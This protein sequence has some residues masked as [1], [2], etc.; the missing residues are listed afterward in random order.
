MNIWQK[1]FGSKKAPPVPGASTPEGLHVDLLLSAEPKNETTS[2]THMSDELITTENVSPN[3]LKTIFDAAFMESSIDGDGDLVV[4]DRCN[5][6]LLVSENK[7]RIT[8]YVRFGFKSSASR[9]ERLECANKINTEW[10]IVRARVSDLNDL[11]VFQYDILIGPGLSK[12]AL[13][14]AVKRFCGIPHTAV[15]EHGGGLIE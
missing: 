6:V 5:C 14:L 3:F 4:K 1:C 2:Q 9:L 13:V 7:D 8:L 10:A 11:L 15:A 12:K